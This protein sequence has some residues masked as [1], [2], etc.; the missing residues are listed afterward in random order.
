MHPSV[1]A[2]TAAAAMPIAASTVQSAT[3][4]GLVVRQLSVVT[5]SQP[6]GQHSGDSGGNIGHLKW[7]YQWQQ[8][9]NQ[10][11]QLCPQYCSNGSKPVG[12]GGSRISSSPTIS[13]QCL[14]NPRFS[15]FY[16]FKNCKK[17]FSRAQR[18]RARL[19]RAFVFGITEFVNKN[20]GPFRKPLAPRGLFKHRQ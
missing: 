20:F 10:Q 5:V 16:P 12:S 17:T 18:A 14:K 15:R 7:W 2:A 1:I 19:F 4:V 8:W 13:G 9:D 6:P 11:W 3:P